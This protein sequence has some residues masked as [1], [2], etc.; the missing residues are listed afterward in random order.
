MT[1]STTMRCHGWPIV[2][3][4]LIFTANRAVER[5]DSSFELRDNRSKSICTS[6]VVNDGVRDTTRSLSGSMQRLPPRLVN[7]MMRGADYIR[8]CAIV[9][10]P[11][12]TYAPFRLQPSFTTA[13]F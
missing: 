3:K 2:V 12:C 4:D 11:I 8:M 5:R 7:N 9:P 10:C 13:P 1:F 6:G